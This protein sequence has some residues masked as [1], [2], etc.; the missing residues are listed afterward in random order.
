MSLIQPILDQLSVERLDTLLFRGN[1]NDWPNRHVFGGHVVAQ[2][3]EAATQTVDP[4]MKVHSLHSYFLRPGIAGQPI[5]YDVDAIRD[6]RSFVTRRVVAIQNGEAIYTVAASFHVGETGLHHQTDM[7][8]VPGPDDLDDDEEYYAKIL[9]A[10][11]KNPSNRP[12]MPFEMRSIDRMDIENMQPKDQVTGYWMRLKEKID[13]PHNMHARLLAYASD[14]AFLSSSLRP[15]GMIPRSD[16]LKSVASLDHAM[17]FHDD[18]F[19]VDDW[20]YYKTDGFWAGDGRGFA[21]GSL[22]TQSG[23]LIAS[24]TQ[25]SLLRLTDD[26]KEKLEKAQS[27]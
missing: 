27:D 12:F 16:R 8:D 14:F 15:H 3:L 25:E 5:I 24:T 11:Q 26:A 7:P 10:F 23:R 20:V 18:D 2:A 21:R 4:A 13:A 22:Y 19:R 9:R 17:W 6:G 1:P